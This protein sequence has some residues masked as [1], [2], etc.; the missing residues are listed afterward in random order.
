MSVIKKKIAGGITLNIIPTDKFKR[1]YLS[2]NFLAPLD[3]ATASLNA[4]TVKVLRRGTVSYP[5]LRY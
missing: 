5:D 3:A 1:E 2:V 4:L